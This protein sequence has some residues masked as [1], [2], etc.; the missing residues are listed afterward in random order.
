MEWTH[1]GNCSVERVFHAYV[2]IKLCA[3]EAQ[4]L[5]TGSLYKV[6]DSKRQSR[7]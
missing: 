1:Q 7:G 5:D 6:P 3:I 4:G 2:V